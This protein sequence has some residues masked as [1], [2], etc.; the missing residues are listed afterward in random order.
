MRSL[1]KKEKKEE[2]FLGRLYLKKTTK[3]QCDRWADRQQKPR[4]AQ[5]TGL[6]AT[7]HE[8]D[9]SLDEGADVLLHDLEL[10]SLH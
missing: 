2:R 5:E 3:E 1:Q 10:F 8:A 7:E 9:A 6:K 4:E